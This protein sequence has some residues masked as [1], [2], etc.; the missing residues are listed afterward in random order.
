[1]DRHW[2]LWGQSLPSKTWCLRRRTWGHDVAEVE[3]PD[4]SDGMSINRAEGKV[5]LVLSEQATLGS[6]SARDRR[7]LRKHMSIPVQ[8]T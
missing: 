6:K 5:R 7:Q 1:M 2:A 3:E 4:K 8:Q